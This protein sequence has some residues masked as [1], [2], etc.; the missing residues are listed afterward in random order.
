MHAAVARPAATVPRE[1]N[2][3]NSQAMCVNLCFENRKPN[4]QHH[5]DSQWSR[6][7]KIIL[8][9]ISNYLKKQCSPKVTLQL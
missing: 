4:M 2:E 5:R 3:Q 7:I 6:F 8:K 9:Y 1:S